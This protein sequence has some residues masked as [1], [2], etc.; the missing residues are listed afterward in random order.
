MYIM[1]LQVNFVIKILFLFIKLNWSVSLFIDEIAN[2][3]ATS[4]SECREDQVSI[5]SDSLETRLQQNI[6]NFHVKCAIFVQADK[7]FPAILESEMK[8]NQNG[9]SKKTPKIF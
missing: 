3:K 2:A 4:T 9:C 5:V 7:K 1:V 6:I 8:E